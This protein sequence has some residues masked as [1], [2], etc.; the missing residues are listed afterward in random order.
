[1]G[2]PQAQS[3]RRVEKHASSRAEPVLNLSSEAELGSLRILQGLTGRFMWRTRIGKGASRRAGGCP[4]GLLHCASSLASRCSSSC[5]HAH[6]PRNLPVCSKK[7]KKRN[8]YIMKG[9]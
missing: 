9:D 2:T 4:L 8:D 3:Q 5:S 7:K 6:L 1:M